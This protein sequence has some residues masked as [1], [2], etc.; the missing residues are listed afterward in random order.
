ML[1]G[2]RSQIFSV[3]DLA[4]AKAWYTTLLGDQPYF[5]EPFYV[6]FN[7]GGYELGLMPSESAS[8]NS[9]TYWGV[10]DADAAYAQLITLGAAALQ[11]ISDVGGDIRLGSV[12]DPHGNILGVIENPH[13]QQEASK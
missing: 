13:F 1:S 4:A 2:L 11:P 6:G 5:D 12:T 7:I 9:V 8:P 3:T 10:S